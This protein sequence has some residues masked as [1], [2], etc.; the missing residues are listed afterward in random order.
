MKL[1]HILAKYKTDKLFHSYAPEYEVIFEEFKDSPEFTMLEIGVDKGGSLMAW[2]EYFPQGQ[3]WGVDNVD[4]R[5][6]EYKTK[7]TNFV[8]GDINHVYLNRTWDI[9]I[10]DGSHFLE[11]V[12][13]VV[14][15]YL[16][17][18]KPNGIL[19][20]EDVQHPARWIREIKEIVPEGYLMS[21]KDF[22]EEK[23][24]PED[25]L[26]IIKRV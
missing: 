14:K 13:F 19:I 8:C 24:H 7:D 18:L 9:V 3:I 5:L 15:T 17:A 6:P 22:R 23:G 4:R 26:I 2:K 11:D 10:D 1:T 25:F 20:I 16:P 12:L 21:V